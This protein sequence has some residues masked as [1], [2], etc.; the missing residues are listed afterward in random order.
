M[1][2]PAEQP[3]IVVDCMVFV[4]AAANAKN[5]VEFSLLVPAEMP[6]VPHQIAFKA[7][8]LKRDRRTV[9][10]VIYTSVLDFPVVNPIVVKVTPPAPA[11]LDAKTGATIELVGSIERLE[12][13]KGD[14]VLTLAGLPSGVTA[15][16]TA[17][18]KADATEFKFA[19]KFPA[20]FKPG[21]FTDL[22]ISATAKPYGATQIKSRDAMVAVKVLPPDPAPEPKPAG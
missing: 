8:L 18:V 13:A 15:P 22:K 11:K 10:A 5:D 20:N 19:L 1:S 17:N 6:E 2:Q 3:R 14:V 4:Q 16:A 7:E 9:E 12:G 21:E